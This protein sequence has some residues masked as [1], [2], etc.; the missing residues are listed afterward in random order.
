MEYV[1]PDCSACSTLTDCSTAVEPRLPA[2][3][4]LTG[5]TERAAIAEVLLP[6][7]V[8][9]APV[10]YYN[11]F[12]STVVR[13]VFTVPGRLMSPPRNYKWDQSCE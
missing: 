2:E 6:Q 5:P 11:L 10:L 8:S 4:N 13:S 3:T 7:S 12:I 9:Q 1:G